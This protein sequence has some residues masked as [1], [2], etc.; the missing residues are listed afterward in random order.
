MSFAITC[1]CQFCS[2][3]T[4]ETMFRSSWFTIFR[5]IFE[6]TSGYGTIGLTL[7]TPNNNY[8]FS[9]EFGTASKLV[10]IVIMLRGRH[11]GLPV[12]IDRCVTTFI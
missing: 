3:K 7:G 9:G 4:A 2:G 8:A 11:R 12:A 10:M 5:I 6:C 1:R